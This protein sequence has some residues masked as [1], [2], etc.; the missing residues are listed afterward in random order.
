M[1]LSTYSLGTS[2][3]KTPTWFVLLNNKANQVQPPSAG[4]NSS[5]KSYSQKGV[6]TPFL[7]PLITRPHVIVKGH[8]NGL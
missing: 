5:L 7:G 4:F 2:L 6:Y 3:K 8:C 1:S